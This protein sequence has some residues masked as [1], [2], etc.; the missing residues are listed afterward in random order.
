MVE[1]ATAGRR[2]RKV[3]EKGTTTEIIEKANPRDG[4]KGGQHGARGG[5]EEVLGKL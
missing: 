5:G 1:K 4:E 2:D 3:A